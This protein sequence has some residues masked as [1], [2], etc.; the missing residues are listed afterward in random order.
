L[1]ILKSP[2]AT[3]GDLYDAFNSEGFRVPIE[4]C[5]RLKKLDPELI[6]DI[7]PVAGY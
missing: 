4:D 6:P 1:D 3:P 5:E 7:D 2:K